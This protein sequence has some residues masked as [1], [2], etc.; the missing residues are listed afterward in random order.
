VQFADASGWI[1]ALDGLETAGKW[2]LKGVGGIATAGCF[3][4]SSACGLS[5]QRMDLY[6]VVDATELAVIKSTGTYGFNPS[7]S[8]KYFGFSRTQ[9]ENLFNTL[10]RNGGSLTQ[11]S[12][13]T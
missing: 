8:G 5:E 4:L 12:V 1:Q 10:Y 2:T 3:L 9:T 6:R 13:P 11:T 7:Q